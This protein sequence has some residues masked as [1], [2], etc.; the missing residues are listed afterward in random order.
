[1]EDVTAKARDVQ[2]TRTFGVLVAAGLVTYGCVHLVVA[3]LFTQVAWGWG[4]DPSDRPITAM[5]QTALGRIGL[6]VAAAGMA[7]LV[8]WRVAQ[9]LSQFREERGTSRVTGIAV[10]LFEAAIYVLI[11]ISA[12]Q[13][14]LTRGR[15]GSI[16]GKGAQEQSLGTA[17][18]QHLWSRILLGAIALALC[19]MAVQRFRG[20]I[21]RSF[22]QDLADSAPRAAV[23]IGA[24]GTAAKGVAV[25]IVG[26]LI[27]WAAISYDPEKTAGI[28]A[29]LQTLRK[30]AFGPALLTVI[31]VGL[32]CYGVYCFIWAP[33]PRRP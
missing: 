26:L 29:M 25:A 16:K 22:T 9:V 12:V 32:A 3:L 14:A 19:A 11:A 4:E 8:L 20:A 13:A 23:A 28:E 17:M 24:V 2:H 7:L 6:W 31:A 21:T 27:G 1:M 33:H 18:L 10:R 15:E 30:A 5:A